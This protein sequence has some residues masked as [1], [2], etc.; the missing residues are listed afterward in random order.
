MVRDTLC[1]H[2]TPYNLHIIP[3]HRSPVDGLALSSRNAYLTPSERQIAGVLYKA[4]RRG[5][6]L[7]KGGLG[8]VGAVEGAKS[9]IMEEKEGTGIELRL[10]YIEMNDPESLQVVDWETKEGD[11]RPVVLS[12]A[13]WIGRTRLIDNIILG[14]SSKL[15]T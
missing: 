12:G 5:E 11:G 14:D 1:S 6:E 10:D 8:R 13:L 4:L 15:L 9:L 2:P 7:W 3:T